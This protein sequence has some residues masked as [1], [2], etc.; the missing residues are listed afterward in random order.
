[1]IALYVVAALKFVFAVSTLLLSLSV[2]LFAL[3]VFGG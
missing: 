2:E 3:R 1:M